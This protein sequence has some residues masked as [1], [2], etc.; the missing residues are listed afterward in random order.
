MSQAASIERPRTDTTNQPAILLD[1]VNKWYGA[2]HVLRDV[3]RAARRSGWW[4]A[5]PPA[6]VN[7]P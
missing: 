2:M 5:D 1:K 6:P 4:S 3:T 7:R